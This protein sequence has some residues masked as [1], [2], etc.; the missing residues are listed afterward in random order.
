MKLRK[1]FLALMILLALVGIPIVP[2]KKIEMDVD[3]EIKTEI[4]SEDSDKD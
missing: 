4:R 3:D 1:A 2:P